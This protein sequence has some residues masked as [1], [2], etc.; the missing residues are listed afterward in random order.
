MELSRG[1]TTEPAPEEKRGARGWL[2]SVFAEVKQTV[3][4]TARQLQES[5]EVERDERLSSGKA[6]APTAPA[7]I[8]ATKI[9]ARPELPSFAATETSPQPSRPAF[10]LETNNIYTS[11]T[12]N[13]NE[14]RDNM[15]G[16]AYQT[17]NTSNNKSTEQR[18]DIFGDG[19]EPF[20]NT[21]SLFSGP[22]LFDK[23]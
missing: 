8:A 12:N 21:N 20:S 4:E 9:S 15:F 22:S 7:P 3:Q 10:E 13:A 2:S 5:M 19:Y 16:D 6:P 1:D 14:Q 17:N 23:K 18:D 11:N